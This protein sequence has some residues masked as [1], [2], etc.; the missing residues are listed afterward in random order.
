MRV[1]RKEV[2]AVFELTVQLTTDLG[3]LEDGST[4]ALTIGDEFRHWGIAL[5]RPGSSGHYDPREVGLPADLGPSTRDA[6]RVLRA[7]NVCMGLSLKRQ[8]QLVKAALQR[9]EGPML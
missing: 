6:A 4:L 8:D 2:Q 5:M 7:V 9:Q 1:T 3:L